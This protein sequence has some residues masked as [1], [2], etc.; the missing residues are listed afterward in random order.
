MSAPL[1]TVQRCRK[2]SDELYGAIHAANNSSFTLCGKS[3]R[4]EGWWVLTNN[5]DGAVTCKRCL[6]KSERIDK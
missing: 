4:N 1:Y 6:K 2:T 3:T 5:H